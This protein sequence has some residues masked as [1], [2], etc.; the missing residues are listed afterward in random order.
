MS[1]LLKAFFYKLAR[2]LTFRITLF[3]GIGMA[4]FMALLYLII[5]NG[6]PGGQTLCNGQ[7]L[8]ISSMSPAQNFGISVPI[9][10]CTFIVLE[11]TSGTI[12]NKIIAGNSK[13]KIYTSLFI[14]SVV[15]GLSIMIVY[16]GLATLLGT[17]FGGFNADGIVVSMGGNS[18]YGTS[19]VSYIIKSIILFILVFV[20][21]CSMATFFSTLF[22]NIGPCIPC[23]II[24]ILFLSMFAMIINSMYGLSPDT[25]KE[26]KP[27]Y[28]LSRYINPFH[29]LVAPSTNDAGV[30]DIDN[31]SFIASIISNLVFTT[32]FFAGGSAIFVK[33]D[34]K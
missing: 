22:R 21:I 15:F 10:V 14:S 31:T 34:V 9:N 20:T 12:R 13:F 8:L 25:F 27:F 26:L 28:E 1:R 2:D 3:I 29:G 6:L 18:V 16:A 4:F 11:F 30:M 33:R 17:I 5:G 23:L 7:S 19:S 24:I 32:A